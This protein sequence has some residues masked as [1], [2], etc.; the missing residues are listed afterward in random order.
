MVKS[1][2][3][4][5]RM[6]DQTISEVSGS[7]ISSP[8]SAAGPTLCDS[9][10]GPTIAKSGQ[11]PAPVNLSARQA[12]AAGLLTSGTYGRR[13]TGSFSSADLQQSL[14]NKLARR[15]DGNG[16]ILWRLIWKPMATPSGRPIFRL[17]ASKRRI[18]ES[19][20]G[21]WPTP[22]TRGHKDGDAQSC[23]NVPINASLGRA[24]HLATWPT[25][26]LQ[27]TSG[28]GQAKRAM[29][30]TRHGSNLNDFAMLASWPSPVVNDAKGSDYA[31]ANGDHARPCLKLGGV[32][33]LAS[34]ATPKQTDAKGDPYPTTET[35]RTEL[36]KQVHGLTATGSPAATGSG[37]QLN[38]AHSR[39]LM[40]YPPEWDA[41]AVTAMPSSRKLRQPSSKHTERSQNE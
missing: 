9:P 12:K 27:D 29:G 11:V 38:P 18:F 22:T 4:Q 32:A 1:M 31:Y 40:G 28:G 39:W 19:D 41:C 26:Q 23:A 7:V 20:C 21:G 13:F 14:G 33:K 5:L 6:F 34:W 10:D 16:S 3:D 30:E 35:R 37:G 17:Q 2:S 36:R 8:V 24:V 25:P 15:L